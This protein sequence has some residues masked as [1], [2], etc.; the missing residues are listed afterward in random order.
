MRMTGSPKSALALL[1][2]ESGTAVRGSL[3]SW[4]LLGPV[5]QGGAGCWAGVPGLCLIFLHGDGAM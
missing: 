2:H 1:L 5:A 3:A 4:G